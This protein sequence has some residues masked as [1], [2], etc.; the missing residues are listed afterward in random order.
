MP[1]PPLP[2]ER[3]SDHLLHQPG[4]LEPP[5]FALRLLV[6]G[7][8][9]SLPSSIFRTVVRLAWLVGRPCELTIEELRMILHKG[10]A[11]VFVVQIDVMSVV[12]TVANAMGGLPIGDLRDHK[13][14]AP[15][16][17]DIHDLVREGGL[18]IHSCDG[19]VATD[20]TSRLPLH[21]MLHRAVEWNRL[22]GVLDLQRPVQR[23]ACTGLQPVIEPRG[24]A[25]HISPFCHRLVTVAA[26]EAN[27][28]AAS[29][30]SSLMCDGQSKS[31]QPGKCLSQ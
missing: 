5:Q 23:F 21:C 29:F 12:V 17:G 31:L 25:S 13:R 10:L 2:F 28:V 14:H 20:R 27:T 30:T 16:E 24:F 6:L 15:R 11:G 9:T 22:G 1:R 3:S 18:V 19:Q 7:P 4:I 8:L 26:M